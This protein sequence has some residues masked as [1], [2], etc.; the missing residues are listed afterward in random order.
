MKRLDFNAVNAFV[1]DRLQE[2]AA[3]LK[4]RFGNKVRFG[5]IEVM[6]D[7]SVA[8]S[9]NG[10]DQDAS[11]KKRPKGSAKGKGRDRAMEYIQE[12]LAILDKFELMRMATEDYIG[13]LEDGRLREQIVNICTEFSIL[14]GFAIKAREAMGDG[15]EKE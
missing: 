9:Q 15:E 7:N 3:E 12:L 1:N 11:E 14:H 13:E 8:G 10:W 6:V 4:A 2:L 5:T